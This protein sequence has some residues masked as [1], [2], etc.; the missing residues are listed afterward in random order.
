MQTPRVIAFDIDDVLAA[1]AEGFA[2]FSNAQ[3]GTSMTAADFSEDWMSMWGV[4][5]E[6]M[7]ER[8]RIFHASDAVAHYEPY[9]EALPVLT[10]LQSS[11]DLRVVTSRQRAIRD[12]TDTW[13]KQ[14]FPGVFTD[15]HY[16]GIFDSNNASAHKLTKA[17]VLREISANYL[18]DD[19]LK[20][21]IAAAEMGIPAVLFGSYPWN[22][23]E[24]LP[25]GIVRCVNWKEVEEYF[26]EQG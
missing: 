6:E 22:Q 20:H 1:N 19:Q 12:H 25:N 16:S 24:T 9:L 4:P 2:A 14:Y 5:E 26:N 7:R 10:K 17:D 11:S 21:C 8:S 15:V 18:V 23:T 13:I 3:W